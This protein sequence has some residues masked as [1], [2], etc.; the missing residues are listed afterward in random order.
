MQ[1]A[2]EDAGGEDTEPLGI[3]SE[4]PPQALSIGPLRPLTDLSYDFAAPPRHSPGPRRTLTLMGG[5][6]GLLSKHVAIG[7]AS[8]MTV[9]TAA[10]VTWLVWPK[11]SAP[12]PATPPAS[13][14]AA[15]AEAEQLRKLVPAGIGESCQPQSATP[16]WVAQLTCTTSSDPSGP[17]TARFM[18]AQDNAEM[19]GLLRQSLADAQV[20]VC[21]GNI[22]S[23]VLCPTG[24]SKSVGEWCR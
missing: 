22:Q 10:A 14:D 16:P 18:L 15:T 4:D 23:P 3:S 12:N 17:A 19:Q 20:V 5:M 1:S 7:A 9:A 6:R 24:V 11:P 21:P 8:A 13:L 2:A